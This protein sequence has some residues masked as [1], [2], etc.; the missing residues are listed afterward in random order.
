MKLQLRELKATR[1]TMLSQG[2][3]PRQSV[4]PLL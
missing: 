2:L 1:P 4:L 3:G